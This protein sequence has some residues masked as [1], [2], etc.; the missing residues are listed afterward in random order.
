MESVWLAAVWQVLGW[1]GLEWLLE[2]AEVWWTVRDQE[3]AWLGSECPASARR[4]AERP[5]AAEA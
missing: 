3:W 4:G 2:A 1:L 5:K